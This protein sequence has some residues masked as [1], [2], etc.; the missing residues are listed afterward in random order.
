MAF[1]VSS[2]SKVHV[3]YTVKPLIL[4]NYPYHKKLLAQAMRSRREVSFSQDL[5]ALK[6]LKALNQNQTSVA[7]FLFF[8]GRT[9]FTVGPEEGP[10]LQR[11]R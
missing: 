4:R 2:F 1:M 7:L 5:K 11:R 9:N 6:L 3:S 8:A 10:F